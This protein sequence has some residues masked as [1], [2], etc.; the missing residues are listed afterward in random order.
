M[1]TQ[2]MKALNGIYYTIAIAGALIIVLPFF[3]MISTSL[4]NVNEVFAIPIEWVPKVFQWGNYVTAFSRY[5]FLSY[6][7]NS[8]VVSVSVTILNLLICAIAG[9]SL[10]KFKY[11]GRKAIFIIILATMMLPLEVLMVPLFLITKQL[12]MLNSLQGQIIPMAV[13]AFGIFLMRQFMLE[14]PDSLLESSRIDGASELRIFFQIIMPLSKPALAALGIFTFREIWDAYIWPL[15]IITQDT[16]KT[17]PLG[18]TMFE[19]AYVTMYHELMAIATI[20]VLPMVIIFFFMQ[21]AFVKS[22]TMSGIKD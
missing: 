21:N 9:Y 22:M 13:D 7:K 14:I 5:D 16:L 17:V 11:R 12:N 3:W 15:L 10:A 19:N 4:K 18:M 8:I 6:F 1:N 20:A 2:Q